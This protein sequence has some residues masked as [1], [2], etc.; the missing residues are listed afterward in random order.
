MDFDVHFLSIF[1]RFWK[2]FGVQVGFKIHPKPLQEPFKSHSKWHLVSAC[3]LDRFLVDFPS[4][5]DRFWTSPTSTDWC[6]YGT[7]RRFVTFSNFALVSLLDVL[8][9]RFWVPKTSILAPKIL[10]KSLP[11]RTK[12]DQNEHQKFGWCWDGFLNDFS[13]ILDASWV[14]SWRHLGPMLATKPLQRPLQEEAQ[15]WPRKTAAGGAGSSP[16]AK[17]NYLRKTRKSTLTESN[18]TPCS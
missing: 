6:H 10:S 9:D 16:L 15:K 2:G 14:P 11:S 7:K 13:P 12:T 17:P 4:I 3:F 8:L 5:F 1:H 18:R